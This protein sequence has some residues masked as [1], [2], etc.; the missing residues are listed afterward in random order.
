MAS[1]AQITANRANA[2][3]STGPRSAQ[4]KAAAR[5]NALQHGLDAESLILPGEDPA[6]YQA[7]ADAYHAS[8]QPTTPD[9]RFHVDALIRAD[10]QQ[11]RLQRVEADLYRTILAESPTPSL[12]AALLADTPAVRL[13]ARVQ[14][15]LAAHHRDWF[16]SFR[17]LRRL[18]E[19]TAQ[20]DQASIESALDA[21]LQVPPLP[22]ELASFPPK[23]SYASPETRPLMPLAGDAARASNASSYTAGN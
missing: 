18:R 14:R 16:R 2:L 19:A 12:A 3:K 13:L 10:W 23:R 8:N 21:L 11:R 1:P 4:G 22:P 5:F 6:E 20:A 7:L 15:Q 9:E 17:E